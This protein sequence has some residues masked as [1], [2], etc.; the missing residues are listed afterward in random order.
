VT[1]MAESLPEDLARLAAMGPVGTAL[2]RQWIERSAGMPTMTAYGLRRNMVL[3]GEVAGRATSFGVDTLNAFHSFLEASDY[4][5]TTKMG[6]YRGAASIARH[7]MRANVVQPFRTPRRYDAGA[8]QS[9]TAPPRRL[10]DGIQGKTDGFTDSDAL[11]RV[12]GF[13]YTELE[14][15]RAKRQ[16]ADALAEAATLAYQEVLGSLAA[17][18]CKS[19][20]GVRMATNW[21]PSFVSGREE[22]LQSF[23]FQTSSTEL[24]AFAYCM[25][26]VRKACG[27][28]VR[29]PEYVLR[30]GPADERTGEAR[31][32]S[33]R[34]R[35]RRSQISLLISVCGPGLD[36]A[37]ALAVLLAAAH[38]NS[39]SIHSMKANCL[40]PTAN[41]NMFVLAWT[42]PRAGGEME[43]I[44]FP[45]IPEEETVEDAAGGDVRRTVSAKGVGRSLR[46][47]PHAI[48]DYLDAS[49]HIRKAMGMPDGVAGL[50]RAGA[51]LLVAQ[52]ETSK[53][54]NAFPLTKSTL[55]RAVD[56]F[57]GRFAALLEQEV[58]GVGKFQVR[59]KTVRVSAIHHFRRS[60]GDLK[61]TTV[62]AQHTSRRSTAYYLRHRDTMALNSEET[63]R[64]ADEIEKA[65]RTRTLV[66]VPA[67][68]TPHG[69]EEIGHGLT[70]RDR[71]DS[72]MP[73]QREGR[74]CEFFL[75]CLS[76]ERAIVVATPL[77][78]A[79]LQRYHGYLLAS[80]SKRDEDP[81][82]W[83]KWV[84]HRL[85]VL[86]QSLRDFPPEVAAEGE[87]LAPRLKVEFGG[88]W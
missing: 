50:P 48:R 74:P 87:R 65:V 77:N 6:M 73:G 13:A 55:N 12:V 40:K 69:A 63:R 84:S 5:P 43:G 52:S 22:I 44:G 79:L 25:L 36:E 20:N 51:H 60:S 70:C 53:G 76:C 62:A 23:G 47:I 21:V 67:D 26:F 82:R 9:V 11:E 7:L 42:K 68:R 19:P 57:S 38:V 30:S 2:A 49:A 80:G 85:P 39:N 34:R 18:D 54:N 61:A 29:T 45:E 46:S 1:G 88:I 4:S 66:I 83:D 28:I 56:A 72:G 78:F 8:V 58:P 59:L 32:V 86:E 31:Y 41:P 3:L 17:A 35:L 10:L 24:A 27:G 16:L 71:I 75:G 64:I 33:M 14:S 81:L 37:A 15:W